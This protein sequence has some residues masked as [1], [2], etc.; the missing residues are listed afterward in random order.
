MP[1]KTDTGITWLL[2]PFTYELPPSIIARYRALIIRKNSTDL[3]DWLD[4]A[5]WMYSEYGAEKGSEFN[6]PVIRFPSG[7]KFRLG[8]LKD[9]Q[10]YTKY[11]GHEYQRQLIEELNQIKN[12]SDYLKLISSCRSTLTG[13]DPRVF[14]TTNP[15]G[16]GHAWIKKRFI[17]VAPW[18]KVFET[19]EKV[20]GK[21]VVRTRVFIHSVM[22]DNPVLMDKDPGY[23]LSI[24]AL[25]ESD[26]ETYKAWRFGD[27]NVFAGMFF[28]QFKRDLHLCKPFI[29]FK[30]D[31]IIG[32]LDW[33]YNAPF[34]NHFSTINKI[35]TNDGTK[36][37][38]IKTF[39]ENYGT[40]KTAKEWAI[41]IKDNLANFGLTLKDVAWVQ[42]D[43]AIFNKGTD[44]S[45]SIR[46]QFIESDGGFASIKRGSN[47][48]ISGWANMH[49]WLSIAPDG[50]P[51]WQISEN[52]I[53]LIEEIES[54]VYDEHKIEDLDAEFDHSLDDCR[55][56]LKGVKWIDAKVGGVSHAQVPK[57]QQ[58]ARFIGT[59][60]VSVDLDRFATPTQTISDSGIGAVRH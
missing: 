11:V 30:Q 7:A 14:S 52:C 19:R 40:H 20:G 49:K 55:Y 25:K 1:G 13:I 3:T 2:K 47:D 36:F 26:P 5:S 37:Y 33:G 4:R 50:L 44:G 17:N 57:M 16:L 53:H 43:P 56:C 10:A 18:G 35:E 12:E 41:E 54:A 28:H 39:L 9:S 22:D 59:K 29:P 42:A 60:Q 8:H 58:T 38:R 15:G 45:I 48:R 31:V 27:W 51:Y 24:E 23:V 6:S 34:S 32:G 21:D 46:D